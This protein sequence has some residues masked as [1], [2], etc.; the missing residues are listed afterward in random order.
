MRAKQARGKLDPLKLSYGEDISLTRW[1]ST[2]IR[3]HNEA[4]GT[5]INQM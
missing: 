5:E 1:A 4:L 3:M 2:Y